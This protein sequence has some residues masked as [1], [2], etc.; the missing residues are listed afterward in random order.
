MG[1]DDGEERKSEKERERAIREEGKSY[2]SHWENIISFL[3][4]L[5]LCGNLY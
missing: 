2:C 3:F 5:A 4:D 1:K